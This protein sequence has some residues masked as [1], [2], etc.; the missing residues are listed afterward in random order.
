MVVAPT[1]NFLRRFE[2]TFSQINGDVAKNKDGTE[3]VKV[4]NEWIE[5]PEGNSAEF[6]KKYLTL[7]SK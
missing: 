3:F 2:K 4:N 5:V 7:V 1:E 6:Y